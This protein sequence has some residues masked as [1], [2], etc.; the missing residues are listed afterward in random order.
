M[1]LNEQNNNNTQE[2]LSNESG[3]LLVNNPPPTIGQGELTLDTS[4]TEPITVYEDPKEVSEERPVE[5]VEGFDNSSMF[6][7]VQRDM[8]TPESEETTEVDTEDGFDE[9]EDSEPQETVRL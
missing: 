9:Y 6:N 5:E 3:S 1:P 7:G 2:P 4:V 8:S